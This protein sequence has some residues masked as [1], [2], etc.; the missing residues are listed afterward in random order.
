MITNV[1]ILLKHIRHET[2]L[3]LSSA[4]CYENTRLALVSTLTRQI[5]AATILL[6][7]TTHFLYPHEHIQKVGL[8]LIVRSENEITRYSF[9]FYFYSFIYSY[10]FKNTLTGSFVGS[11]IYTFHHFFSFE[12]WLFT[13]F[14]LLYVSWFFLWLSFQIYVYRIVFFSCKPLDIVSVVNRE[15]HLFC[16]SFKKTPKPYCWKKR[17]HKNSGYKNIS[18][19]CIKRMM[20]H[21]T[22]VKEWQKSI[23][24]V[25]IEV[26]CKKRFKYTIRHEKCLHK[27]LMR[28]EL[29]KHCLQKW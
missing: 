21:L 14:P 7:E 2:L 11:I 24:I 20:K 15:K 13:S 22:K 10:F 28:V 6:P 8:K 3:F 18:F 23:L 17:S 27:V 26:W 29:L 16:Q 12:I 25:Q 9:H 1:C 4:A 5:D 19:N